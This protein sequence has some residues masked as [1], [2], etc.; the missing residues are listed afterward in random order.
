MG[1]DGL[2]HELYGLPAREISVMRP[3]GQGHGLG[4]LGLLLWDQERRFGPRKD[5]HI[6]ARNLA[7]RAGQHGPLVGLAGDG[8]D[9]EQLT[10]G[11][12]QEVGQAD[13]IVNVRADVG[14]QKKLCGH[15]SPLARCMMSIANT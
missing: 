5:R 3:V 1:A 15:Y 12:G 2:P 8:G 13:S 10:V 6:L 4:S 14:V 7:E 11:L 9:A